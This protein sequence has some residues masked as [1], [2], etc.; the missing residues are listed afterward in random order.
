MA[1]YKNGNI[2]TIVPY[3]NGAENGLVKEY[4]E[5]GVLLA[6]HQMAYGMK[7][8][9]AYYRQRKSSIS[10]NKIN[11]IKYNI[12]VYKTILHFSAIKAYL[13]FAFIFMP[14]YVMK[15]IKI[16]INSL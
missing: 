2:K 5:D 12:Q 4:A 14:T 9:L 8:P 3:V 6:T 13:Y 16:K 11:L 10:N 7:E 15:K 1:Y